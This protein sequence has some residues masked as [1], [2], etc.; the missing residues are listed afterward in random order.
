MTLKN[1]IFASN[2]LKTDVVDAKEWGIPKL[3]IKELNARERDEI[4][5]K[6]KEAEGTLEITDNKWYAMM[7]SKS[8][9][10]SN[11]ERMFSD[12][13]VDALLEKNSSVLRR[14]GEAVVELSGY[15]EKAVEDAEKNSSGDQSDVSTS[16]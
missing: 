9:I 15:T 11:G 2:D 10:E 7:I 13:D 14:I 12:D 16:D 8:A 6:V 4:A 5:I 1:Q 3:S